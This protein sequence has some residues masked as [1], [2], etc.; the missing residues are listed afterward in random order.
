MVSLLLSA[1]PSVINV[2]VGEF[3]R[4][5]AD[6]KASALQLDWRPPGNGEPEVAWALG[7]MAGDRSDGTSL[8]WRIDQANA[9][10]TRRM[11]AARPMLV[12]VA[13]HAREIWPDMGRTLTHAGAPIAWERMCGPMQGSLI[14]AVLYEGW[15]NTPEEARR[16]LA[17][18]GVKFTSCHEINA[19]APMSG[20]ISPSM[21]VFVVR[22]AEHANMAYTNMSEGIGKVLRFGANSPAVIDHLR[23]IERV[24]AP[25]LKHAVRS[26]E[27]GIDLKAIQSQAL[28]MGDEVHS[29]NTAASALFY[30]AIVAP[31]M[32]SDLSREQVKQILRFVG[33]NSQFF[34]NL[35]MVSAKAIMDAAHGIP[36]SSIVTAISRNGVTTAI[37]VSGLGSAW[38]EA[39]SDSPI[40]LFFPGFTQ[41]DA[42]ADLGDSAIAE[43]AGFGGL[44]LA[45]SP[46]LVQLVGGSVV[47]AIGISREMYNVTETRNPGMSLPLL[48]FAGAPTGIDVRK[49]VDTGI[50]PVLTTG[51][52]H[53]EAGIGQVGAGMVR[54]P[55]ACFGAA[56]RALEKEL[57]GA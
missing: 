3:C 44:S 49:V 9:E 28:L 46:A 35:S 25:G 12:D 37:R 52:A 14:G 1:D 15:A 33:G 27:G 13:L 38:F 4:S 23:W 48:D 6:A 34:L 54:V 16:L 29:R 18:G 30:A 43:T 47:E 19:V 17:G 39:P 32:E 10:A 8:G 5:V 55:M 7:Q 50:R 40:G 21:P 51:I 57:A 2:G 36:A 24:L 11:I 42:N 20:T 22:N 56:L 31:L 53:K 45:A 26:I 41:A